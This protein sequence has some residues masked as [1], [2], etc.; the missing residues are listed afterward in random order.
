MRLALLLLLATGCATIHGRG[1]VQAFEDPE[2]KTFLYPNLNLRLDV[3]KASAVQARCVDRDTVDDNGLPIGPLG[4]VG[5]QFTENGVETIVVE[6]SCAGAKAL[7]HELGHL[8]GSFDRK[9]V[10]KTYGWPQEEP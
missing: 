9:T 6:R 3:L 7:P 1:A 4:V 2:G 8:D 5:C 10:E